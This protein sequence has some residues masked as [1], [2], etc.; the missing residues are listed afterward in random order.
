MLPRTANDRSPEARRTRLNPNPPVRLLRSCPTLEPTSCGFYISEAA[1]RGHQ[2]PAT[3]ES[4][5]KCRP[6]FCRRPSPSATTRLGPR[7]ARRLQ[8]QSTRVLPIVRYPAHGADR[9][10][11]GAHLPAHGSRRGTRPDLMDQSRDR[12]SWRGSAR[13]VCSGYRRSWYLFRFRCHPIRAPTEMA[14]L[15][16]ATVPTVALGA[17]SQSAGA[18][19][20]RVASACVPRRMWPHARATVSATCLGLA[21]QSRHTGLGPLLRGRGKRGDSPLPTLLSGPG[22]ARGRDLAFFLLSQEGQA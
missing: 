1:V 7:Q 9:G 15:M 18:I 8:L 3:M 4:S 20:A 5:P 13:T 6:T 22:H 16:L 12:R 14:I 10:A 11:P 17:A 2:E 19:T 21:L